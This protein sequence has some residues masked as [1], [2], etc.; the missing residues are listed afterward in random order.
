[1]KEFIHD[2]VS[3]IEYAFKD[4][5]AIFVIG[6]IMMVVSIINK[7]S[8]TTVSFLIVFNVF[9]MVVVGYGSYISYYTIN[10]I[11]GSPSIMNFKNLMWEGIKKSFIIEC[12]PF[13]S[14]GWAVP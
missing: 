1:M 4:P 8:A 2:I 6:I 9:M 12:I 7:H 3:A 5:L 10:G 13:H 11:D 14:H